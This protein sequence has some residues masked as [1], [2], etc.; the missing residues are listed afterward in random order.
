MNNLYLLGLDVNKLRGKTK[1]TVTAELKK[2]RKKLQDEHVKT[3]TALFD[4]KGH[5]AM[6]GAGTKPSGTD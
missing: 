6:Y 4:A 2:A 3:T 5:E 1:R